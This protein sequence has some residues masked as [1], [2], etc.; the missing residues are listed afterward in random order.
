MEPLSG[1]QHYVSLPHY[2]GRMRA[3]AH[4]RLRY[5]DLLRSQIKLLLDNS[6]IREEDGQLIMP[7]RYGPSGWQ[8]DPPVGP[9]ND[10]ILPSRGLY[11]GPLPWRMQELAHLY[12]AS[13]SN[14][15]YELIA[16]IRAG[17]VERDWNEIGDRGHEKN[18]G[19]TEFSRFQYYDGKNPDWPEKILAAE[20]GWA[21]EAYDQMRLDNRSVDEIISANTPPPSVILTKG[22]TQVTMGAPQSVYNGGLLRATVRYFD[23]H[24]GRPR[25]AERCSRSCE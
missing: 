7:T 4:R 14:E 2:R 15:D 21:L 10:G 9:S 20:Y 18:G 17:E 1:L 25:L 22:L 12:H 5:L 13:M 3:A 6:I 23:Q 8:Y 11:T 16:A 19:E 24:H